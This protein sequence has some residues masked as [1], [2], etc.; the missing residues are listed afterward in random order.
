MNEAIAGGLFGSAVALVM[1]ATALRVDTSESSQQR[2]I[3]MTLRSFI[4][5][6]LLL[7][8]VERLALRDPRRV[9]FHSFR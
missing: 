7:G 3:R 5:G 1:L 2:A 6:L 9:W 4:N 8:H